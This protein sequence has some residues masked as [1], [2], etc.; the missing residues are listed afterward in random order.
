ML[1]LDLGTGPGTRPLLYFPVKSDKALFISSE[2]PVIKCPPVSNDIKVIVVYLIRFTISSSCCKSYHLL[3]YAYFK[4]I[5]LPRGALIPLYL[6]V[7][8]YI[9]LR[10]FGYY[11]LAMSS[12][13]LHPFYLYIK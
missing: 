12:Q 3:S 8:F 7:S 9:Y 6:E 11:F 5:F 4:Y 13:Q 1:A 2:C 10:K